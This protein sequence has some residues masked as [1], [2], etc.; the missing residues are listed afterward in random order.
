MKFAVVVP[1]HKEDQIRQ[2]LEAWRL[3]DIPSWLLLI[4]DEHH[5][6]CAITK[7]R[8]I[9][10]ALDSRAEIICV[11]DSDCYP[12]G[13]FWF[14]E[15]FV[16][17]HIRALEPQPVRLFQK[18]TTP[19]SRGTPFQTDSIVMPVAASMGFWSG[20]PDF[21]APSQL[22][23]G[24]DCTLKYDTSSIHGRYFPL[25]GMNLAFRSSEFPWCQFIN[26]PRFDDIWMGFL[27][28]R[29]AYSEGK[30]FNLNGPKIRHVR[31]SNVFRNLIE[32]APNIERNETLWRTI[33]T[34]P[35]L[36]HAEMLQRHSLSL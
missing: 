22:V 5:E 21:D 20:V 2:F 11:L 25:C 29:K 1:W 35:L 17:E 30:C 10:Q 15:D 31:Q 7:N 36:S 19:A 6:G 24:Q 33:A 13:P 3:V 26:V 16:R 12:E 28:Q 4:H 18:V 23:Y 32:E 9:K 27:W 14:M 34:E 8:G